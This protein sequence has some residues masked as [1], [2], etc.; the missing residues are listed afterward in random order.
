[1]ALAATRALGHAGLPVAVMAAQPWAPAWRSRFCTEAVALC[2]ASEG[3]AHVEALL[4][5]V[6]SRPHSGLFFCDE[7]TAVLVGRHRARFAPHLPFLLPEQAMLERVVDKVAMSAFA[8]QAA[9]PVPRTVHVD[10]APDLAQATRGLRWPWVVKGSGGYASSHLRVVHTLAQAHAAFED[11]RPAQTALPHVQEWV[12]GEVFSVLA[13]CREGAP[14][15]LFHMRKQRTW[16]LWGGVCVDAVSVHEPALDAAARQVLDALR[17]HGIVEIEFVRDARD[18]RFLLI[19]ACPDPNW[20]LDLPLACGLNLPAMAW[21]LMQ[22]DKVAAQ[23]PSWRTGQRFVWL[24]PE[25]LLHMRASPRAIVPL[26]GAALNPRVASDLRQGD[27]GP[28]GAQLK[29]AW[30]RWREGA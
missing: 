15:A 16:P 12:Q 27:P 24:L 26:L 1:M 22:G 5:R 7:L 18:G 20:G 19:E 10:S 11:L 23:A 17:W 9:L 30:W 25:G 8:E 4:A 3:D 6:R 21:R 14:V 29:Q 13:L 28:L 2:D